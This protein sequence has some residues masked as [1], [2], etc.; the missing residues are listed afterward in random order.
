MVNLTYEINE[1]EME[2][3]NNNSNTDNPFSSTTLNTDKAFK[4]YGNPIIRLFFRFFQPLPYSVLIGNNISFYLSHYN[5]LMPLDGLGTPY[6]IINI[7]DLKV[8][9]KKKKYIYFL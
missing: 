9:F 5:S 2:Y 6:E 8:I 3:A 1:A 7:N 4:P